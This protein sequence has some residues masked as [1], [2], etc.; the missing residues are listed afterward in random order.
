MI[1]H[2]IIGSILI[3]V[4]A[5]ATLAAVAQTTQSAP[6]APPAPPKNGEVL[7]VDDYSITATPYLGPL[8]FGPLTYTID[9]DTRIYIGYVTDKH[10]PKDGRFL[11]TM[12]VK[13]GTRDDLRSGRR[14]MIL[15]YRGRAMQITIMPIAPPPGALLRYGPAYG[16]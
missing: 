8:S 15:A 5:P 4:A 13:R 14:V 2:V 9:D 7:R 6:P 11:R 1:K 3:V 10:D 16:Y 12:H